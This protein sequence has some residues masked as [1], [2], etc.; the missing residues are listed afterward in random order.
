M[1]D[2]IC[3]VI[4]AWVLF[5]SLDVDGSVWRTKSHEREYARMLVACLNG[6]GFTF[7]TAVVMC[8]STEVMK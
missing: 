5:M 8:Q 7:G 2:V 4:L 3:A 6:V 1:R